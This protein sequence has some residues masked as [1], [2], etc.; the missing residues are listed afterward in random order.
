MNVQLYIKIILT[1]FY[2]KTYSN[3][4]HTKAVWCVL[5]IIFMEDGLSKVIWISPRENIIL[6]QLPPLGVNDIS[7]GTVLFQATSKVSFHLHKH[8]L[9][10]RQS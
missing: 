10:Y 8:V 1:F 3:F 7:P 4:V 6:F 5:W 2:T 9:S